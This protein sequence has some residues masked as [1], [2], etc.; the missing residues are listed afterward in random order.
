MQANVPPGAAGGATAAANHLIL[1]VLPTAADL[2]P[3]ELA[4]RQQDEDA[5][6]KRARRDDIEGVK[7]A[8]GRPGTP[9]EVIR[10]AERELDPSSRA[11]QHRQTRRDMRDHI[12]QGRRDFRRALADAAA[13]RKAGGL[14]TTNRTTA[15]AEN[16]TE[17]ERQGNKQ[18]ETRGKPINV[19]ATEERKRPGQQNAAR[20]SAARAAKGTE[21]LPRPSAPDSSLPPPSTAREVP[22]SSA[23]RESAAAR[24]VGLKGVEASTTQAVKPAAAV[25]AKSSD[26]G[27]NSAAVN[28]S[29]PAA[30]RA[31]AARSR[32]AEKPQT[33]NNDANVE[34]ILRTIRTQIGKERS[35]ATLRLEPPE[36]GTL[37][38]RMD[39]HKQELSLRVDTHTPL[40][41]RLLSEHVA[42]LRE[43][44]E[45]SGIQLERIE[46]R[47]PAAPNDAASSD[48]SAHPD[49]RDAAGEGS[50][51][52]QT[53]SAGGGPQ[54]GM[55][56]PPDEPPEVETGGSDPEPATESLVNVLA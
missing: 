25:G 13:R 35:T 12:A 3:K 5:E 45:A 54:T 40:A 14:S 17:P 22:A 15:R 4:E 26:S 6:R 34:R 7:G 32:P 2:N 36:L 48:P 33:G 53:K 56:S 9:V 37:R 39:L 52:D 29:D 38:L 30:Q 44:L 1:C 11:W 18:T 8:G 50:E 16:P 49:A 10:S 28:R 43:G 42:S 31:P 46:I 20:P 23:V 41:H 51:G 55:D 47:P 19:A 27:Q 24:V 21:A